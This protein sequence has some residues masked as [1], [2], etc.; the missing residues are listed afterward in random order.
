MKNIRWLITFALV[1]FMQAGAVCSVSQALV[2]NEVVG[3]TTSTDVEFIELFGTTGTSLDGLSVIVVES[4]DQTNNGAI[5]A[6]I[7]LI[8]TD[9]IGDNGFFLIGNSLVFATYGETP[10]L[11]IP[12]N[13]IENSSYTV[14]LVETSSIQGDT[15]T[16]SEV[17][18]DSVG[19]TD[20]D[21][22][23]TFH[24]DSPVIGP[25]GT[26]L[27]AGFYRK[28]DGVDTDT[29]DDFD[30][31]DFSNDPGINTPTAG[32]N[33]G[34]NGGEPE[35]VFIHY[36]QG[37]GP[38]VTD[39]GTAVIVEAV[40]IGDSQG[41]DELRGFFIQE[42]DAD[43]DGDPDTSEGIFVY[44][45]NCTV[46]VEE[47]DIV[48]VTG[49]QGEFYGMSQIDASSES[50]DVVI[51]DNGDNLGLVTPSLVDLPAP[52][53][54]NAEGTFEQFEGMLVTFTSE[55][56][57]T[58]YYQLG[59]YGQI[60]L[61]EGGKP[62]QFTDLNGP[63]VAAY[64]RYLDDVAKRRIILDD[65]NNQQNIDNIFHPQPGGF[66]KDNFIRGGYTL[67]D[68]TGVLHWSWAGYSDTDA[69]RVRPQK[70][71]PVS[72]NQENPR[73]L[74]PRDVGG[75][76]KVASFNVLNYFTTLDTGVNICGPNSDLGCRGANSEAELE[77]QTEKIIAALQEIDADIVGLIEI[78]NNAT[79]A[80]QAIVNALNAEN[81]GLYSYINT[82]TIGTDAIKVAL[83]YKPA[84]VMPAGDFAILDTTVNE[85]FIDTKN[86]PVL[87]QTFDE[88]ATGERFTVAVNHLKSK[89]S[90]CDSI[91]DPNV[92]DG[93]GNCN[94]TRTIAAQALINFLAEDPTESGD[95]DFL[96]IG[97]LN[98][99][100]MEDPIS[101]FE[102]AGYIN[103]I[104]T[105]IGP[106][107]Y[108]YVFDGQWG[109]LDHALASNDLFSQVTGVAEWNINSDEANLLDYNDTIVDPGEAAYQAKPSANE[110]FDP[111]PYRSSDHDPIVI[112]IN[113]QSRKL[114]TACSYLGDNRFQR[115]PD[116]DIFKF[117][118]REGDRIT[119]TLQPQNDTEGSN[120]RATLLLKDVIR[121]SHLFK[122]KNGVLPNSIKA[123]LPAD[124]LYLVKVS[125]PLGVKKKKRYTGDYCLILESDTGLQ[126]KPAALVE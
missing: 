95:P 41:D 86:R 106:D 43:V 7:D 12:D 34:G 37:S 97:D 77:R 42:E 100:A 68:L 23:D 24:F 60:V 61:S 67:T 54:T 38:E 16:G 64:E 1:F 89:G 113:L 88:I 27:P 9:F 79:E 47:G 39:A 117:A 121:G 82:G 102:A 98:S 50:D 4:D 10:N 19:V 51:V 126:L 92:G 32:T 15:V 101:A 103:L 118:G 111:G 45:G 58:E 99:Y 49:I 21:A 119:L 105:L 18:I 66:S 81:P 13:F 55:L 124:G 73:A 115:I 104:S 3:S 91:G 94:Q 116:V 20:G 33:S 8:A 22:N 62:R 76:I 40:V 25:D 44:C 2:L 70:S 123:V 78:E 35:A 80:V 63:D 65:L 69:W 122:R 46:D 52:A 110:L 5:D 90:S 108:S 83:I 125:E 29:V 11:D 85:N 84:T 31:S 30:L 26:Y 112:G 93:Q 120:K 57:V 109:Y 107:A 14:A 48:E 96:V 71:N 87:I 28:E 75:S 6:R 17:I 36:I 59:R 114:S 74:H 56:T 72:F 53:T